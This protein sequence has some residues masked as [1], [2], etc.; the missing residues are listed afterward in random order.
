M[1]GEHCC[2]RSVEDPHSSTGEPAD[3]HLLLRV[4]ADT[5]RSLRDRAEIK[6]L[7]RREQEAIETVP[8]P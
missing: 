7:K 6:E 8:M 3:K 2:G 4:V 5:Q 1:F